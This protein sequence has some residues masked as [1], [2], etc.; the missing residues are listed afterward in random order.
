MERMTQELAEKL[1]RQTQIPNKANG[2][3]TKA[4]LTTHEHL[5]ALIDSEH[6]FVFNREWTPMNANRRPRTDSDMNWLR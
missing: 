3:T 5:S 4:D 1:K 2:A 6:G